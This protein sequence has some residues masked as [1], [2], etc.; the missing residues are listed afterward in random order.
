CTNRDISVSQ[1]RYLTRG[2]PKFIVEI[3]NTCVSGCSPSNIHLHCGWFAS[4]TL[5]NPSY[6]KRLSYDD[7]LVNGGRPLRIGQVIKFTYSNSFIYP[8]SFKTANF[9]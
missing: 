6:F 8:L 9:C 2:I 1:S 3:V 5:V 4:A 7:C